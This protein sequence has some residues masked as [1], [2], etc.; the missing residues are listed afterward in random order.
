MKNYSINFREDF[1]NL[2][3]EYTNV[4]IN[5]VMGGGWDLN[6]QQFASQANT[7]SQLGYRHHID[8]CKN[9]PVGVSLQGGQNELSPLARTRRHRAVETPKNHYSVL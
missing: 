9:T 2:R 4:W 8:R 7:S 3:Y 5:E 6:P 1:V